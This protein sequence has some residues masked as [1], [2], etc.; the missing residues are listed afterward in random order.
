[1]RCGPSSDPSTTGATPTARPTRMNSRIGKY[2]ASITSVPSS[3]LQLVPTSRL[4]L[5]RL[6]RPLAPQA[7]VSTNF[8]TWANS[9]LSPKKSLR[10]R[11][12]GRRRRAGFGALRLIVLR[13]GFRCFGLRL[14]GGRAVDHAAGFARLR[15]REIREPEARREEHRGENRRGARKEIGR[16]G[17]A[18]EAARSAA[19]ESRAHVR[20]LAVLKQ[21]QA[22]DRHRDQ[23]VH[24]DCHVHP[25]THCAALTISRNSLATSEA[26]PISPPSTS[27]MAKIAAAFAALT[28]PPYRILTPADSLARRNACTACACSGVA[29]RPVPMAQTGS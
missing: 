27:G 11:L 15:R 12:L 2:S 25:S 24:H 18:E 6:F 23:H 8:T 5:L 19:A 26:P 21:H 29:L 4:E 13:F 28:L 9:Q 1:G 20:A 7:S 14:R 10:Y 16:S 17:R 3:P 22:D